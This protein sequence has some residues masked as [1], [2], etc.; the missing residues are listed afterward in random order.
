MKEQLKEYVSIQKKRVVVQIAACRRSIH[1]LNS[2]GCG[3]TPLRD[4]RMDR[5]GPRGTAWDRVGPRGTAWGRVGPRGIAWDRVG[6]RG[7]RGH[8]GRART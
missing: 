4:A 8:V 7:I 5:V 2:V 1:S 3:I 6:P